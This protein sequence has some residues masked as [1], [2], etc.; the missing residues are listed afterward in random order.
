MN[1]NNGLQNNTQT[2]KATQTSTLKM[3][4]GCSGRV[5]FPVEL[6][7]CVVFV[8]SLPNDPSNGM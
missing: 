5:T 3:T 1:E 4:V 7:Q 2:V 8:V 6:V